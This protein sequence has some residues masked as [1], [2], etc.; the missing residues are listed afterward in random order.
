M[1]DLINSERRCK[2]ITIEDPVEYV[3]SQKK[4]IIIQQEL[5]TDV[6][7]FAKASSMF[8]ARIRM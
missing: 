4:A 1:I 8:S 6:K 2:I 5:H 7:S 3:H